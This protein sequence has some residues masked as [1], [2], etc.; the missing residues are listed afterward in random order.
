MKFADHLL[1]LYLHHF[2]DK[3]SLEVFIHSVLEQMD[4]DEI[5]KVFTKCNKE[6]L[7]DI[8][9]SYLS[10]NLESRIRYVEPTRMTN[11]GEQVWKSVQ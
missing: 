6:E 4:Y 3:D 5:V 1:Q 10:N 9:G 11:N 8:L 7:H 2:D